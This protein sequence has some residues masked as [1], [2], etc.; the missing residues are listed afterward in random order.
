VDCAKT[1]TNPHVHVFIVIGLQTGMRL[2]EILSIRREHISFDQRTIFIPKAKSGARS[3]PI[4]SSLATFLKD[5]VATLPDD[6][7]WLFPSTTS[8]TGHVINIRKPYRRVVAAADLDLHEVVI[9][10]LRH[11]AVSHLVQAGVDLPTIQRIS[12][13]RTLAMV[14][15]YAH[16]NGEHINSAMDKLQERISIGPR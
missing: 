8:K 14:A 12:G 5:Y 1:D 15:R 11:T 9:H 16:A 10:T 13:H 2:M 3:Q 4:T 6:R 7:P